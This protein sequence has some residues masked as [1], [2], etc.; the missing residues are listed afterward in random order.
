MNGFF[1]NN[2]NQYNCPQNVV[3]NKPIVT[4]EVNVVN[5]YCIIEQPHI[6]EVETQYVNHYITRHQYI[7]R[8]ISNETNVYSEENCPFNNNF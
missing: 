6:H 5:R 3:V 4:R 2:L 1:N 8:P 7:Q